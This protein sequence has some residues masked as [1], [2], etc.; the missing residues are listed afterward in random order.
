M[1][2][3]EREKR[4]GGATMNEDKNVMLYNGDCLEV[5][6]NFRGG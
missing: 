3:Y 4:N 2:S 1:R 5:L 6:K